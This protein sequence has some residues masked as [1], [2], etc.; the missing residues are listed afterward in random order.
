MQSL[1]LLSAPPEIP[2]DTKIRGG[3]L[4]F[5]SVSPPRSNRW[6]SFLISILFHVLCVLVLPPLTVHLTDD[7][8]RE[9]MIRQQ[10]QLRTLRIRVP[11]QLSGT[12][13][14]RYRTYQP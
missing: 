13:H 4:T 12:L 1:S 9:L 2:P 14:H 11:E 7:S 8:D 5:A 10:R 6:P 3:S